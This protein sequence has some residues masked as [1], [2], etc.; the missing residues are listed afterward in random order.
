MYVTDNP[1]NE[2]DPSGKDGISFGT[3]VIVALLCI[4]LA[5]V[6]FIGLYG[7]EQAT[8]FA[9][10]GIYFVLAFLSLFNPVLALN[11]AMVVIAVFTLAILV[12]ALGAWILVMEGCG[13]LTS[14]VQ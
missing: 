2:V 8:F 11:L 7:A 12:E 6:T 9:G 14:M 3:A 5:I 13:G 4:G 10:V 1:V